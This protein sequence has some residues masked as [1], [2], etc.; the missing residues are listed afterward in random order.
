MDEKFRN[1]PK[2]A[3][4]QPQTVPTKRIE[5][6]GSHAQPLHGTVNP[7]GRTSR[8]PKEMRYEE[9]VLPQRRILTPVKKPP[10][11]SGRVIAGQRK[12]EQASFRFVS[13][14]MALH[15]VHRNQFHSF[16]PHTDSVQERTS[17]PGGIY[18]RAHTF[19]PMQS[20]RSRMNSNGGGGRAAC[21]EYQVYVR[22]DQRKN[23]NASASARVPSSTQRDVK[24]IQDFMDILR[25]GGLTMPSRAPS[26][27]I[28]VIPQ[29]QSFPFRAIDQHHVHPKYDNIV[30]HRMHRPPVT[31]RVALCR[32]V[33]PVSRS[34]NGQTSES[35]VPH[36]AQRLFVKA[37]RQWSSGM[38]SV[39]RE[40]VM[41]PVEVVVD[42]AF[43]PLVDKS[44][45]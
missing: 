29:S 37:P 43:A 41:M 17:Y 2:G 5:A 6:D 8:R 32:T 9:G 11:I 10:M 18:H 35:R 39:E 1:Q 7:G 44:K 26:G 15:P 40:S 16:V 33:Q 20:R 34:I 24:N 22:G 27:V 25:R 23:T 21:D 38:K 13:K 28:P 19:V 14:P 36:G 42:R 4:F 31:P 3:L 45:V 12:E 30:E